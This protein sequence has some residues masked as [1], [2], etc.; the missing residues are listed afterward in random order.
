MPS[1]QETL[2]S[3]SNCRVGGIASGSSRLLIATLMCP[4]LTNEYVSGVPQSRQ[5]PHSTKLELLN[6]DNVPRVQ[7][8]FSRSPPVKPMKGWPDAFWHITDAR[9]RRFLHP[10]VTQRSTLAAAGQSIA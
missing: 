1:S 6:I 2:L 4:A 3:T 10:L 5:K 8:K 9:M 7:R